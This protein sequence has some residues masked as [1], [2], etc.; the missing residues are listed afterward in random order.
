MNQS[1]A[2]RLGKDEG[3][4]RKVESEDVEKANNELS[5]SWS[6]HLSGPSGIARSQET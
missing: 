5:Q 2:R 6:T 4:A 1:K 3:D